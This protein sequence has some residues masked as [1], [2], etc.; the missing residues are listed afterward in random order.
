MSFCARF[1]LSC[2]CIPTTFSSSP[3][4]QCF[5][6]TKYIFIYGANEFLH[7]YFIYKLLTIRTNFTNFVLVHGTHNSVIYRTEFL[8]VLKQYICSTGFYV[9]ARDF[10]RSDHFRK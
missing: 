4:R 5:G 2:S 10:S 6:S 9:G 8:S 1:R 7:T 3:T